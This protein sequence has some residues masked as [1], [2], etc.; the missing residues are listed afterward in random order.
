METIKPES[1]TLRPRVLRAAAEKYGV[2]PEFPWAASPDNAVLRHSG[3]GKWFALFLRVERKKLG[4]PESGTVDLL[5]VK[6]DPLLAGSFL[7]GRGIF[8]GYHMPKTHWISVLLDGTVPL[9]QILFLLDVSFS[10]TSDKRARPG[11]PQAWLVPANPKVY[12]VERGFTENHGELTWKQ[13]ASIA[14]GDLVYL[15]VTAPVCAV[16][17]QCEVL[18]TDIPY[19]GDGPV[20]RL[21][22]L[23]RRKRYAPSVM[24]REKMRAYGVFAVRS[25]RRM[26][27]QMAEALR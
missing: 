7:D 18:E 2:E 25:P 10:L 9:D 8:P 14:R 20:R 24:S 1:D 17:Y 12:D 5:D 21:M 26:P 23:K 16:L 3:S 19:S 11:G 6:C 13:T 15:Y 27:P 22:R 4:L